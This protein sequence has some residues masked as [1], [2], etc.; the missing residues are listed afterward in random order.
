MYCYIPVLECRTH[1]KA[2]FSTTVD[3]NLQQIAGSCTA[4]SDQFILHSVI[5]VEQVMSVL[6]SISYHLLW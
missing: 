2:G 5:N 6:S 4:P 3:D 1:L